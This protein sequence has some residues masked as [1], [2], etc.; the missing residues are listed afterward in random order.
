MTAPLLDLATGS[1]S[2]VA[3]DRS[4]TNMGV[5]HMRNIYRRPHF[6]PSGLEVLAQDGW[7]EGADKE[8]S[9]LQVRAT[10]YC[11]SR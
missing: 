1:Q 11:G 6:E 8:T 5:V 9:G 3:T 7:A 10:G 4:P 2:L